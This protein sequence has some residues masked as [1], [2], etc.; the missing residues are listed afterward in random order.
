MSSLH[1]SSYSWS[2]Y[3]PRVRR[4]SWI[5]FAFVQLILLLI[6]FYFGFVTPLPLP[7]EEG[8]TV[9]FGTE[10]GGQNLS[11]QE[12]V[13][14]PTPTYT[15]TPTRE[16][17]QPLTQDFEEAPEVRTPEKP[18]P[19]KKEETKP[20]PTEQPKPQQAKPQQ[21]QQTE[22][23]D[24]EPPKPQ[25]NQQ[26][27]FPGRTP[28]S[29]QG[30]AGTGGKEGNQGTPDGQAATPSIGQGSGAGTGSGTGTQGSGGGG[31]GYSVG[32]RKALKLPPPEYPGQK[33]GKVVV[34][35]W[36]NKEGKVV[37]AE[38][39]EKGS[40]LYD[41][42]FLTASENAAMQAHF[43]VAADAPEMQVGTITYVFRLKQ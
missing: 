26:A 30:G 2:S 21:P 6:L 29:Q 19:P 40:T 9:S 15:P 28:D 5:A 14:Q 17:E 33:N 3:D 20:K 34:K 12:N 10:Q 36:V 31:I 38:A 8:V 35:V 11:W 18:K 23:K 42:T 13:V 24:P 1:D 22:V 27:L 43:D 25:V 37:K 16:V 32:N 4:R 7:G 39:G 41:K